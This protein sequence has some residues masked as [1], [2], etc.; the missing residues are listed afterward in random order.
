TWPGATRASPGSCEQAAP[1]STRRELMSVRT[2]KQDPAELVKAAQEGDR[3]ALARLIS[4][5]EEGGELAR[6]VGRL[7]FP[8]AGN[9]YTVGMT[10]PTGSGKSTLTERLI[11]TVR[12]A[13]EEVGVLA[14]DPSSPFSG[15]AFLGD[16]VR[17]QSPAP[18]EGGF[19][20]ARATL[21]PP[22]GLALAAADAHPLLRP[23][24]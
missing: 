2:G 1:T 9:A 15:G 22:A 4:F 16:R 14:V 11:S 12:A 21:R 6:E 20:R 24:R 10:G 13:G 23:S 17:M 7:T 19:M 8:L 5:V 3:G 18:D